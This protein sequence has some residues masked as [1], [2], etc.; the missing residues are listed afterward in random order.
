MRPSPRPRPARSSPASTSSATRGLRL[1]RREAEVVAQVA[2]GGDAQRARRDADQL[3]LGVV[4]GRAWAR[5][6]R[7]AAARA[8]AGRRGARSA[9]RRAAVICAAPE[10]PLE[11]ALRRRTSPT[12]GPAAPRPLVLEQLARGE[13][14][15][16]ARPPRARASTSSGPLAL[17]PAACRPRRRVRARV[18][19]PAQ[20]RLQLDRQQRRL[21]APVLEQPPRRVPREPVEQRR[22]RT[23]RAG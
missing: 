1:G 18:H 13:R 15:A 22:C 4:D 14:A 16:L 12:T 9:R 17:R 8:R 21:V 19:P 6:G 3:A 5:R 10:Q 20:Q 2:L 23:G 7:R 11:R